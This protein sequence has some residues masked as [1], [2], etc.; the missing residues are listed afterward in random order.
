MKRI[1]MLF[2]VFASEAFG[3]PRGGYNPPP[4][5]VQVVVNGVP[6]REY[7]H[8]GDIFVEGRQGDRYALRIKN[9]TGRRVEV[10][11]TVDGLDV[12]DGKPGDF[13]HKRG[14]VIG[15]WQ[16]YDIEGFRL[17]MGRVA[18]FRFSSVRDSY[19]AS[20]G[21]TRN[22]GVIGVAFFA[23]REVVRRPPP[24]VCP[25]EGY[26]YPQG[27]GGMGR[28][29]AEAPRYSTGAR[30]EAPAASAEASASA[31]R[32]DA[33][34]RP[35]LGTEF[36]EARYS[37]VRETTFVRASSTTPT[38]VITLRYNDRE[39][40]IAMG[41]KLDDPWADDSYL[42]RTANPFPAN[43]PSRTFATPPAGWRGN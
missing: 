36:G 29:K 15:P 41:V 11:A 39:G 26:R 16:T 38:Q 19:A 23:E 34:R 22:V 40:L 13:V 33:S 3:A 42:R 12:V 32:D 25:K 30:A 31:H 6:L 24:P 10:V 21:D 8:D 4:Y 18:A 5:E 20:K 43:P 2:L 27:G 35:G 9:N 7:L 17:D 28:S 1:A 37:S 14:Y